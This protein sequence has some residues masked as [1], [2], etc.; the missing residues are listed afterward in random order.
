MQ[1]TLGMTPA[2]DAHRPTVSYLICLGVPVKWNSAAAL[3][4][5]DCIRR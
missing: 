2:P 5:F 1:N 3:W 4:C